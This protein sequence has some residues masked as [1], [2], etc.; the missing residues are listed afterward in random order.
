MIN[1]PKLKL[2]NNPKK[3]KIV[4]VP[5]KIANTPLKNNKNRLSNLFILRIPLN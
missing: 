1:D 2:T 4:V 3:Y 5:K